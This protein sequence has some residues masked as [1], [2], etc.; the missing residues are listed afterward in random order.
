MFLISITSTF[1]HFGWK[2]KFIMQRQRAK[3]RGCGAKIKQLTS[4]H[5]SSTHSMLMFFFLL[6]IS[7]HSW[8]MSKWIF[9]IAWAA[10]KKEE[11][12]LSF[13]C[14]LRLFNWLQHNG[15]SF[16]ERV[17]IEGVGKIVGW[18]EK[19]TKFH[20]KQANWWLYVSIIL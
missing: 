2:G 20:S 3:A 15:T 16:T 10:E 17:F 9:S 4:S 1:H 14:A 7:H 6:H 12:S 18:W 19:I 8:K 13:V 11:G 5:D